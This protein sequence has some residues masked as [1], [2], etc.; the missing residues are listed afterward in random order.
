MSHEKLYPVHHGAIGMN[1]P[2]VQAWESKD[3]DFYGATCKIQW[4]LHEASG[5]DFSRT[6]TLHDF[7]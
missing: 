4:R 7:Y 3:E 1:G 6:L 2:V 5:H